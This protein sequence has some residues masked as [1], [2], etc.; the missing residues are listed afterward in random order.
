MFIPS[1]SEGNRVIFKM[2]SQHLLISDLNFCFIAFKLCSCF[3]HANSTVCGSPIRRALHVKEG[4]DTTLQAT[5]Y[6]DK[7]YSGSELLWQKTG[8]TGK[9]LIGKCLTTRSFILPSGPKFFVECHTSSDNNFTISLGESC[10]SDCIFTIE[11]KSAMFSDSGGYILESAEDACTHLIVSIY[12]LAKPIC[13]SVHQKESLYLQMS[14]EWAPINDNDTLQFRV[15]NKILLEYVY[16]GMIKRDENI[17][18]TVT[19]MVPLTGALCESTIPDSCMVFLMGI[20]FGCKFFVKPEVMILNDEE[21]NN[22]SLPCCSSRKADQRI[23][24]YDQNSRPSIVNDTGQSF[25]F[26]L[27][28]IRPG[29]CVDNGF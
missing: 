21:I 23:L 14:C 20:E 19:S 18:L 22:I 28:K 24:L 4:D 17:R 5:I 26:D 25:Q 9:H 7:A 12:V 27:S 6:T 8:M 3:L 2:K 13:T 16:N 10:T 11:V 15:G 1:Y 29:P